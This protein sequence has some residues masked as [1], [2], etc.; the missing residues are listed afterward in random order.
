M[1]P[2][3]YQEIKDYLHHKAWEDF[4]SQ[5]DSAIHELE[6]REWMEKFH[7]LS[8]EDARDKVV[9]AMATLAEN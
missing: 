9:K 5:C 3:T 1:A 4:L 8:R 7:G 6:A 2:L